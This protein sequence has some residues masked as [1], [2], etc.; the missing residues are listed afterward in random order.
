MAEYHFSESGKMFVHPEGVLYT[1]TILPSLEAIFMDSPLGRAISD[2]QF[3]SGIGVCPV[4][5]V[6]VLGVDLRFDYHCQLFDSIRGILEAIFLAIWALCA[7][8]I[9]L[10]A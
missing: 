3:P 10:S 5:S 4:G 2:I 7:V 9:L 1:P 8:R 6:E